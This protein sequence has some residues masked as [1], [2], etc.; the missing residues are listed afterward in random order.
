MGVAIT[1][2][3]DLEGLGKYERIVVDVAGDS[4]ALTEV[5]EDNCVVVEGDPSVYLDDGSAVYTRV[6]R[7]DRRSSEYIVGTSVQVIGRFDDESVVYFDS[8]E[9]G[10]GDSTDV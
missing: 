4:N 7:V 1:R 9:T 6:R 8:V 3:G 10:I 5:V 2:L